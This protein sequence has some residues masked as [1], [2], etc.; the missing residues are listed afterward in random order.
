MILLVDLA[1]ILCSSFRWDFT[2]FRFCLFQPV[3]KGRP[4]I[5]LGP[6]SCPTTLRFPFSFGHH[7]VLTLLPNNVLRLLPSSVVPLPIPIFYP[8]FFAKCRDLSSCPW[9]ISHFH[10]SCI[11][12]SSDRVFRSN[13]PLYHYYFSPI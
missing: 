8:M 11:P 7:F 3:S 10:H 1:I 6:S 13:F 9:E 4:S 12:F 2:S 5:I